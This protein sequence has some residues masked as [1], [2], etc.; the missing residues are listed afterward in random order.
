MSINSP[1]C[2]NSKNYYGKEWNKE[3]WNADDIY[4]LHTWVPS[5]F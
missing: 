3:E 2:Y 4:G 1:A 5:M